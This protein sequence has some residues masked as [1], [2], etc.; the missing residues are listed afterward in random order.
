MD[1]TH[2]TTYVL[3][4]LPDTTTLDGDH[5][6][7][8]GTFLAIEAAADAATARTGTHRITAR[9]VVGGA[10]AAGILAGGLIV[11]NGVVGGPGPVAVDPAVAIEQADGWTTISILDP[12]A[13]PAE[14]E[15]ALDAAGLDARVQHGDGNGAPAPLVDG[16]GNAVAPSGPVSFYGLELSTDVAGTDDHSAFYAVAD[17]GGTRPGALTGFGVDFVL[18]DDFQLEAA[19]GTLSLDPAPPLG[20]E[21]EPASTVD[22][23]E[24]LGKLGVKVGGDLPKGTVS[25]RDGAD[26]GIVLYTRD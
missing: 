4:P 16:N 11:A 14:I 1:H 22:F 23:D 18:P 17:F 20:S 24:A 8:F 3:D 2:T 19:D 26:V 7:R 13:K 15:A 9:R 10:L 21:P 6:D 12:D 5:A 25:V